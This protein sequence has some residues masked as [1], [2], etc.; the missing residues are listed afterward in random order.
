MLTSLK[1]LLLIFSLLHLDCFP[2]Y[3]G[4]QIVLKPFVHCFDSRV[5][6]FLHGREILIYKISL[7][8]RSMCFDKGQQMY[9]CQQK[10][11][12]FGLIL[13]SKTLGK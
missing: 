7:R 5:E 8:Q 1:Q 9:E 4:N 12:K 11:F 10:V 3:L 13:R 6:W 2:V